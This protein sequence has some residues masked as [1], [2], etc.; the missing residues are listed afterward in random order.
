MGDSGLAFALGITFAL[1]LF[2][3]R[4]IAALAEPGEGDLAIIG[5]LEPVVDVS[6]ARVCMECSFVSRVYGRMR[7]GP[8]F[9]FPIDPFRIFS[10]SKR[11][12]L[13]DAGE[14]PRGY[15]GSFVNSEAG[16]PLEL[17]AAST[18]TVV[19]RRQNFASV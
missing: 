12:K 1:P 10:A 5:V 4:M 7:I 11:L 14:S 3:V 9:S 19:K 18:L 6:N 2:K 13:N 8:S 16:K 17:K 15:V